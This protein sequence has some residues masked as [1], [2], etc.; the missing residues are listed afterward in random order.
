MLHVPSGYII[1]LQIL[2]LANERLR[3]YCLYPVSIIEL[4]SIVNTLKDGLTL[5]YGVTGGATMATP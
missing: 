4:A 3:L 1:A 2:P 5:G